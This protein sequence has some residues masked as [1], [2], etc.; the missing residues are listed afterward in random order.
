M[1][2]FWVEGIEVGGR[3]IEGRFVGWFWKEEEG[4]EGG[5]GGMWK[6]EY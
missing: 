2:S 1:G 6:V 3:L 4:R 5:R